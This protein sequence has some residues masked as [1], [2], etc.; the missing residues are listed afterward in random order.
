MPSRLFRILAVAWAVA[1][2]AMPGVVAIADAQVEAEAAPG[3]GHV[4]AYGGSDSCPL[5]HDG[6]CGACSLLRH[7]TGTTASP[8][9][10]AVAGPVTASGRAR[11]A[12]RTV[13]PASGPAIPR[14]PPAA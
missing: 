7:G 10:L 8:P 1:S 12:A 2:A 14:A 13:A 9:T 3:Q 5:V 4:E 6:D 11:R